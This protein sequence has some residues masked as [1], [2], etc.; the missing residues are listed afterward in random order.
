M[1]EAPQFGPNAAAVKQKFA[2]AFKSKTQAEWCEIFDNVDACVMPVLPMNKAP[3]NEH[4]KFQKSFLPAPSGGDVPKP[5]PNLERT[6]GCSTILPDPK[7]GEHT[8]DIL[9]EHGFK[10]KEWENFL[11]N[12]V[13]YQDEKTISKL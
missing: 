6:P 11:D 3:Q 5:A 4:S 13:V 8:M 10:K 12:K 7:L 2:D 9:K 1:E